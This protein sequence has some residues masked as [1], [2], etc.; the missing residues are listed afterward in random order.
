MKRKKV[1]CVASILALTLAVGVGCGS[2]DSG[3]SETPTETESSTEK[4]GSEKVADGEFQ[5]ISAADALAASKKGDTHIL[6]VREWD[7]YA[8]GRVAN[9]EWVPIFPLEDES[10]EAEMEAYAKDKLSDGKK[11]YIVCNSGKRGA[12]KTTGILKDA[13]I[14]PSLIF[15]IEGGAEALGKEKNGL[16]T[17]RTEENIDWKYIS[18]EEALG[19]SDAQVIDVRD[20]ENYK[21]GHLKDSI[22]SDLT[23]VEDSKLQTNLYTLATTEL[24]KEK[25]VYFLCYSG[26]KCA[27]TGISVLKDAG[28]NLDNVFIIENGAKD[29]TIK[30]AFVQE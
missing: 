21:A 2:N 5:Y 27:K 10:L 26:N 28:F 30:D 24:D 9:S 20:D 1:L 25:P 18:G 13:G 23:D 22:H 11:I 3:N 19:N 7:K 29:D 6:D 12:E 8:E 16:T 4:E 14:D 17:V 15:T